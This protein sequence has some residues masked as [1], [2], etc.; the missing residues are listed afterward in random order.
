MKNH[1]KTARHDILLA[2]PALPRRQ[3]AFAVNRQRWQ[4]IVANLD[5]PAS[6]PDFQLEP[7]NF[8]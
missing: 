2:T 1:A 7:T 3:G 5:M 4:A 6:V 8:H